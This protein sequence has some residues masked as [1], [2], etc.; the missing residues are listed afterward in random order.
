M[1]LSWDRVDPKGRV[2]LYARTMKGNKDG[3]TGI[4]IQDMRPLG[5]GCMDRIISSQQHRILNCTNIPY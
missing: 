3:L 2:G 4:G 1:L 5:H